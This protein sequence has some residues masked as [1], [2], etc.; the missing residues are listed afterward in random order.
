MLLGELI[1]R[2]QSLYSKG[3]QSQSTRLRNR[4]IYNKLL[5]VRAKLISQEVKR[6]QKLSPQNFQTLF[7]VELIEVPTHE[8]PCIPPV[9]CNIIRS[10]HKLPKFLSGLNGHII[11]SVTNIDN[12]V[13]LDEITLNA[14]KHLKGNK[15]TSNKNNYF[16]H[17][18]YL[19]LTEYT[20]MRV[21]NLTALFEDP[22]SILTFENYCNGDY[23]NTGDNKCID[24][25]NM[26]FPIDLDMIDVL[27]EFSLQELI[28][29][30][31]NN[32]E[33]LTNNNSDNIKQNS[34]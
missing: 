19:Y 6:K 9:G 32:V 22:I 18:G 30:F 14:V 31:A 10:K 2:V 11:Q 7:C 25:L 23:S 13:K 15:Y 3:V 5:T 26:E 33:D 20:K 12:S 29:V 21:V 17:N 8:C 4:H 24:Y 27:I 28:Q 16:I 34:K 1:Q